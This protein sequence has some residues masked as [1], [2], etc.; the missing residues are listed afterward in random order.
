[1]LNGVRNFDIKLSKKLTK[2]KS[3]KQ[4]MHMTA[5]D[6]DSINDV[7]KITNTYK[8]GETKFQRGTGFN[9]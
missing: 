3:N 1:M 8:K 6:I 9:N 4:S 2:M 7:I 5:S